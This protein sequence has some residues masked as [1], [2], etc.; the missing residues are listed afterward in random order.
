MKVLWLTNVLPKFLS[1]KIGGKTISNLGWLDYSAEM[2][3]EKTDVELFVLY[4]Y[5]ENV[6]GIVDGIGYE[7]FPERYS[8]KRDD[9]ALSAIFVDFLKRTTPDVIH[10]HGTEYYH[11]VAMAKAAAELGMLERTVVSIQGLVSVI[12]EH[13]TAGLPHRATKKYTFRDFLK[14]ENI[15]GQR[16]GFIIRGKAE[17]DALKIIPNVIGRTE[18]DKACTY[19]INPKRRYYLCNETLR[20]NFYDGVW[21]LDSCEKHSIFVSQSSYSI[22]ALHQVV[23]ALPM[24]LKQYPDAKIYVTGLDVFRRKWYR[25]NAY[26]KYLRDRI[27]KLGLRDKVIFLGTLDEEKMK[28]RFLNSH[29]FVMSSSIENSPNSLGEAMLLGV[30]SIAADVGGVSSVFTHGSDG[31]I[32]PF[33]A[34][35]MLAYYACRIFSENDTANALSENS[36]KHA[37]VTH[38]PENNVNVLT[39]I[40][41]DLKVKS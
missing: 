33:D 12:A 17:I 39:Q 28:A 36:K 26:H 21:S 41:S 29:V 37:N 18:W 13:Y 7:T 34:P 1:K 3:I 5:S 35:Y 6:K 10:I 15:L 22:K 25:I 4:P 23:E 14:H 19:H 32:Y 24:I 8:T 16:K 27:K 11:T 30:P 31:F 9:I 2:L 38:D 20:K 40:Y